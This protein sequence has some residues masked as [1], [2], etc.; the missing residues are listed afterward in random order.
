MVANRRQAAHA[1][2]FKQWGELLKEASL[3]ETMASKLARQEASKRR[4]ERSR[5]ETP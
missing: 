5:P 2:Y 4:R 3:L 1:E